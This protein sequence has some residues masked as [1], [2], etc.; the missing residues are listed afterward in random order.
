MLLCSDGLSDELDDQTIARILCDSRRN[1][2][3]ALRAL[4]RAALASGGR[5]NIT[6]QLV[7]SPL[8]PRS[9]R[10]GRWQW[11]PSATRRR[12][13]DACF[14]GAALTPWLRVRCWRRG[15]CR[16]VAAAVLVHP[17]E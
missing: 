8:A 10:S 9:R 6:A 2:R 17:T 13:R 11:I 3:R 1:H 4:M 5:D 12:P 7:Q 16:C 15:V 14:Y